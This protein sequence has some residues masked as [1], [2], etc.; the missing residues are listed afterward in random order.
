VTNHNGN[1]LTFWLLGAVF[2]TFLALLGFWVNGLDQGFRTLERRFHQHE[3]QALAGYQRIS[4]LEAKVETLE[5]QCRKAP[6]G[7]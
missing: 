4:T 1:R 3:I 6:T 2:T 7:R 5:E